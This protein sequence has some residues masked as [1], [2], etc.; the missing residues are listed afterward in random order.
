VVFLPCNLNLVIA[1]RCD[2]FYDQVHTTG[3]DI[4]QAPNAVACLTLSKDMVFRDYAQGA[5]RMRGIRTGQRINVL[6]VPEVEEMMR[7][8]VH[9]LP[10]RDHSLLTK[11]NV[12]LLEDIACWLTLRS[13]HSEVMQEVF[14]GK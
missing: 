4:K 1:S 7:K 10:V 3:T 6:V 13:I 9:K 14:L 2:R 8:A 5:Y 11:H 12:K